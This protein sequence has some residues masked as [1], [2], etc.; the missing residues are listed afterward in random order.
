MTKATKV[1]KVMETRLDRTRDPPR[2]SLASVSK[3][4]PL[5]FVS[6]RFDSLC[7][8]IS[9][10]D[11][12][13][14]TTSASRLADR[15][16]VSHLANPC[17]T[18]LTISNLDPCLCSWSLLFVKRSPNA[19]GLSLDENKWVSVASRFRIDR[20][21]ARE[22]EWNREI[23]RRIDESNVGKYSKTRART[24]SHGRARV[25]SRSCSFFLRSQSRSR[26]SIAV[27]LRYF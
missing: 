24:K 10:S 22:I 26:Y 17:D 20:H 25:R 2:L 14:C 12:D 9:A 11:L 15:H 5:W 8:A 16:A 1:M 4:I 21:L 3:R 19:F 23:R 27:P 6:L 18:S 7:P 13:A